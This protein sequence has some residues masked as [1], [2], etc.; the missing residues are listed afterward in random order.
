VALLRKALVAKAKAYAAK[1]YA[2]ENA[3]ALKRLPKK[4]RGEASILSPIVATKAI[5]KTL[6]VPYGDI[7]SPVAAYYY[8]ENGRRNPLGKASDSDA[9]LGR[10]VAARRNDPDTGGTD[11]GSASLGR[12]DTVAASLSAGTGRAFS[13]AAAKALVESTGYIGRGTKAGIR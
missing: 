3:A 6:G 5:A 11:S 2:S 12:W 4:E 7:A 9:A 8:A 10:L 13:V 1:A